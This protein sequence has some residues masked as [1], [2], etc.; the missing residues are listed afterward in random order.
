MRKILFTSNCIFFII[1]LIS[2]NTDLIAQ[3]LDIGDQF[4]NAGYMGC[5]SEIEINP[6]CTISPHSGPLCIKIE[7]LNSCKA[8]W[9]GVYWTNTADDSGANWGQYPG[10]DFSNSGYSKITFWARGEKG[11]EV[12]EFGSGGINNTLTNPG[13]CKYKD[14]YQ[15]KYSTEGKTLIL[16]QDWRQYTIDLTDSDLSSVIGG[17]FWSANWRAN[18]TGLVF[19]LDDIIFE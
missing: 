15:K 9:A 1:L 12:V 7:F 2:S 11:N 5:K 17:F 10:T 19:Y 16:G 13:I 4:I 3:S 14:S 18:P 8:G 6:A